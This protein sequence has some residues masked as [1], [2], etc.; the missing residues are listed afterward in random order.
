MPNSQASTQE[1]P[2][3]WVEAIVQLINLHLYHYH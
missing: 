3:E 1:I 2:K